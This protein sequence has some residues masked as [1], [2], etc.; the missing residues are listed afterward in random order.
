MSKEANREV[1]EIYA[2]SA[3]IREEQ[4]ENV[5]S[6][7]PYLDALQQGPWSATEAIRTGIIDGAGYH[8]DLLEASRISPGSGIAPAITAK[9]S[10]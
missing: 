5:K 6:L 3:Y 7:Q 10:G 2:V 9:K 4:R 8:H 1:W